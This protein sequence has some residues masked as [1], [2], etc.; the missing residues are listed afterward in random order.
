MMDKKSLNRLELLLLVL[1]AC[2]VLY[3][4]TVQT[5][6][7]NCLGGMVVFSI[8]LFIDTKYTHEAFHE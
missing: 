1:G 8:G 4:L 3:N 5:D 7:V 2:V 6:F